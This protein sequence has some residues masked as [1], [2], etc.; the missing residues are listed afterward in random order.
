VPDGPLMISADSHV[1][2]DPHL[3]ETR[4]PAKLREAAPVFPERGVGG[5]FQ[6][7]QG[8]WDPL[9][10]VE[11]M[12][13]DGV[14]QEVLYP[15]LAMNLFGLTDPAL[16]EACF[17]VYNDWL[18]EYC[19]A[20]PDRLFGIGALC[21][22][23]VTQAVRELRR[24]K[25]AGFVGAMV[26]EVPPPELSFATD[27][28]EELWA[29]AEELRM[30]IS[31][32]ILTGASYGWPKP[33]AARRVLQATARHANDLVYEAS[34]AISDLITTGVL[35]R[36]PALK[37]VLVES[38]ASWIPFI[39]SSWDK[40]ASRPNS[41][42]PLTMAPSD[43]FRR[44]VHAT[45]F[46]DPTLA[47]VLERWGSANC[48]WSN[49]Y[50]HPNSTWPESRKI[51]ERDLGHLPDEVRREVLSGNVARLYDLPAASGRQGASPAS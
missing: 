8:G 31:L 26:W 18:L 33:R 13:V 40:Y 43:Y 17:S 23:D 49:D 24:C 41:D 22:F 2:E 10:R 37:F 11:E 46:N 51:I 25:A 27:H 36:F 42:S 50:P 6:A 48:M 7:H 29:V 47:S 35:E 12:A 20:A 39:L 15:S 38:E 1:I 4:L 44:N 19:S 14:S 5:Q 34:N 9:A 32:H 45:F 30:P 21:T 3:W 16:Q 28:Y